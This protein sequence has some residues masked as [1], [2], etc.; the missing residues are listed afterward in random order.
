MRLKIGDFARIG[1]VTVQ[2]LRYYDDLGLL[3]PA[4]V[5]SLTGYCYYSWISIH[6]IPQAIGCERWLCQ[7]G[8]VIGRNI[9]KNQV[10]SIGQLSS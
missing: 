10:I 4:E 6:I 2:T 7:P 9:L 1:H 5:D 8:A 3:P